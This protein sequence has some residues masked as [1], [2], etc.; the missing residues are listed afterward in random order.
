MNLNNIREFTCALAIK[1]GKLIRSERDRAQFSSQFKEGK[2]LVT[3]ADLAADKLI[4]EAINETFPSHAIL[5]EESSPDIGRVEDLSLPLW[6][7]DP[8]DGTV[9][10]AHGHNQSAVSIACFLIISNGNS[11]FALLYTII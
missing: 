7:I 5:S 11:K 10:F 6:I 3:S 9:N 4:C 2:E 8:I 1:A